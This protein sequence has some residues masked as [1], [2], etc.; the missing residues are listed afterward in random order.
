MFIVGLFK[1]NKEL[2]LGKGLANEILGVCRV[3]AKPPA[4]P[5]TVPPALVIAPEPEPAPDDTVSIGGGRGLVLCE[6][7][8]ATAAGLLLLLLL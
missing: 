5:L 8:L 7:D 2:N 4:P 3:F 1:F 6:L